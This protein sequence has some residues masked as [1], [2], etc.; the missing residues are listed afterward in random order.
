MFALAPGRL[1]TITGCFHCSVSFW[2]TARDR[3]SDVPPAG[4]GTMM[5]IALAGYVCVHAVGARLPATTNRTMVQ[6]G[7]T[8]ALKFIEPLLATL[9]SL[10]MINQRWAV[11]VSCRH[12]RRA[13]QARTDRSLVEHR[14]GVRGP[15]HGGR[16]D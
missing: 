4:N 5:R 15:A 11:L 16:R 12:G 14:H 9:V 2:P 10:R 1:S 7:C 6:N 8:A 3:M 13:T